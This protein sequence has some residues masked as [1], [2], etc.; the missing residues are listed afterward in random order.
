MTQLYKAREAAKRLAVSERT[1]WSQTEPRGTIPAVRIG[2]SVRY[3]E[4]ALDEWIAHQL[5]LN[6]EREVSP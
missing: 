4:A 3:S 5:S 2:K 6:V 1:L